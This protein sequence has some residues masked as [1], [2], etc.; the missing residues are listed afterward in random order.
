VK[1][2]ENIVTAL[3][4]FVPED[5]VRKMRVVT[6]R[7]WRWIPVLLGMS[8]I[9]FSPFVIIRAGRFN[10]ATAKGMALLAHETVHIGQVRELRWRFYPKY[11]WGQFK[12]GF[13]HDKHEMEVPGIVVQ[14]EVRRVLGDR[15]GGGAW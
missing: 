13:Q 5:D 4:E 14:R 12:C 7:P 9:T 3:A 1:L 2:P 6:S 8:A 11:L 15:G 10:T